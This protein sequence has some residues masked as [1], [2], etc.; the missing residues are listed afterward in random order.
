MHKTLLIVWLTK[1]NKF[2]QVKMDL[3]N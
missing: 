3:W 2:S 1:L